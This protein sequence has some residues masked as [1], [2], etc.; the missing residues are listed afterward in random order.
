MDISKR[1]KIY[2]EGLIV[3]A[4]RSTNRSLGVHWNQPLGEHF[5]DPDVTLGPNP[6]LP[7]TIICVAHCD[8]EAESQKKFWRNVAELGLSKCGLPRKPLVINVIFEAFYKPELIHAMER[9]FDHQIVLK[10][11]GLGTLVDIGPSLVSGPLRNIKQHS[12]VLDA[13]ATIIHQDRRLQHEFDLLKR[14]LGKV[15]TTRAKKNDDYWTVFGNRL[16]SPRQLTGF[17]FT[18]GGAL[19]RGISKLLCFLPNERTHILSLARSNKA[20]Q[21]PQFAVGLG[22]VQP[23]LGGRG[24]IVDVDI[25][26]LAA[27]FS[28]N[29]ILETIENIPPR[30]LG[31]LDR[32]AVQ[33]CREMGLESS[34]IKNFYKAHYRVFLRTRTLS[35]AIKECF[36]DPT[37]DGKMAIG[38]RWIMNFCL[39]AGKALVD[40][41]QGYGITKL[42]RELNFDGSD[43]VR[44]WIPRY[45]SGQ[46]ELDH[47]HVQAI[48]RIFA[49]QFR[50][51]H[52]KLD[53][54]DEVATAVLKWVVYTLV[55]VKLCTYGTF[56]PAEILF[57]QAC[58]AV[59][60]GV[61]KVILGANPQFVPVSGAATTNGLVIS[62]PGFQCF[63]K[64]QSGS[65]NTHDKAKELA[66][67]RMLLPR[68]KGRTLV[69]PYRQSLLVLDGPYTNDD[70]KKCFAAGW[71]RVVSLDSVNED[72]LKQLA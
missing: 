72:F 34:E 69:D 9:L 52:A 6:N 50:E 36:V 59:G 24:R 19:R 37:F 42:G 5:I 20:D 27:S 61:R 14:V 55:E 49:R 31:G 33:R 25:M 68:K 54:A 3:L 15:V 62:K 4:L 22:W 43:K 35:A 71:G 8:S 64:V 1:L 7:Q 66:G 46:E 13:I 32:V 47:E 21:F 28:D 48:A 17:S 65:K 16:P 53:T 45:N 39:A 40:R 11:A 12:S 58:L 38:N 41:A 29:S 67:R 57:E 18:A 63:V 30:V 44:F 51:L 56:R 60:F 23:T 2:Q 70:A 10:P 26:Q